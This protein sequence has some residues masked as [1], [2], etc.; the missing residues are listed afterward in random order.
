MRR[1]RLRTT[2]VKSTSE[3]NKRP[4]NVQ[5][6]ACLSLKNIAKKNYFANFDFENISGTVKLSSLLRN[7]LTSL[8]NLKIFCC[9][10]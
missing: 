5:R 3:I 1:P 8:V 2:F 10:S 9:F 4:Y 6:N 7:R